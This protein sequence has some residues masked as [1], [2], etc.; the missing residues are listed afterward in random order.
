MVEA[1]YFDGRSTRI[2]AVNLSVDGQEII[3]TGDG[4]D[5][6]LPIAEIRVDERLGRAPRRLRLRDG[7]FCE[8]R[9]LNALDTLLSSIGHRDGRVDRIQRQAK[10][11]LIACVAFVVLGI[12]SWKWGLPWA[13]AF[14][15]RHL[16]PA[17]AEALSSQTL[18]ILDGQILLPSN[19]PF[20]RQHEL[21]SKFHALLLPEGGT[22]ASVLLFRR[23]PQL[24]ANAFTLPDG[25]I[26]VLDDL[27]TVINDDP[28]TLAV[29]AHELGHARG[30]DGLKLLL[31]SS[32]VGAFLTFYIGDISNL[33][34]AAPAALLQ[35]RYSQDL[36]RQAD[37]Y[38]AAVLLR[39]GMSPML[40]A[41]ALNKLSEAHLKT[42]PMGYLS[43]HPPTDARMR[44][45]RALA[46]RSMPG[47]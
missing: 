32:A 30:R 3:I 6:R 41:D 26:I 19:I 9:D 5:L 33:L 47:R 43:S 42:S 18:K 37:D 27:I 17:I 22:P 28:R 45:L 12:A 39:N 16:P 36:E 10:Y 2:R 21:D 35:A 24:G 34:A 25:T 29:F 15:A 13:A 31:Q 11:V 1:N 8:V 46:A 40:L 44:H 38:G 14:G 20:E 7:S 4:I 23:S